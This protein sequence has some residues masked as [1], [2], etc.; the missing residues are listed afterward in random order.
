MG[1]KGEEAGGGGTFIGGGG[2]MT[3][4]TLRNRRMRL[5]LDRACVVASCTFREDSCESD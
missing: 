5:V 3:S 2:V 1:G 4:S